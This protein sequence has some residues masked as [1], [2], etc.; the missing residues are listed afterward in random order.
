MLE[1]DKITGDELCR[2][3]LLPITV[4]LDPGF[5]SER[6]HESFD[7]VT[8]VTLL[9]ETDGRVDQQKK[10]DADE[11]LPIGRGTTTVRQSDGDESCAFHDPGQG[12]PH[13]GKELEE[14]ADCQRRSG[15]S[16]S[17]LLLLL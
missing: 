16:H 13:E 11:I 12:V 7:G 1:S 15:L 2:L 17:L 5:G 10:D 8:S 4:S 14:D 3:D 6:L 9:D